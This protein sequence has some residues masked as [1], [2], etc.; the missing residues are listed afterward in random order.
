M[1]VPNIFQFQK[2]NYLFISMLFFC[3]AALIGLFA[4]IKIVHPTFS[5]SIPFIILRPLHTFWVIVALLSGVGGIIYKLTLHTFSKKEHAFYSLN[6]L[7]FIIWSSWVIVTGQ[8]SG[9]EYFSWPL[10][11]S[12][13][14]EMFLIHLLLRLFQSKKE[15]Y[16]QSPEAFWLLALGLLF[17][18]NGLIESQYW[19]LH[20][21][22]KNYVADLSIQWHSID[23]FFAGINT[24][25]YGGAAFLLDTKPKPLRKPVLFGIA[26]FSLLF[27]FGHHHYISPQPTLLKNLALIASLLAVISFWRHVKAYK[28][29][30]PQQF[31]HD[32]TFPL[33]R[34]IEFW[35]L[36]SV[37]SGVLFAIPQFNLWIHSSYLVVI[38]AM[39]SMI[40]VNF[41]IIVLANLAERKIL[42]S[43]NENWLQNPVKWINLSLLGLW[44]TLGLNGFLKGWQRFYISVDYI[45]SFRDNMLLLFPV[46]GFFLLLGIVRL[47]YGLWKLNHMEALSEL[48]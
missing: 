23:T 16:L 36:V 7:C 27:T 13:F 47:S 15:L 22:F 30:N 3:F 10:I 42:T 1:F 20:N 41:M 45:Q 44:I 31:K 35:T 34:A 26:A 28:K 24:A 2:I 9:R 8:A 18:Q 4:A 37:A 40:G 19:H 39:G 25:L 32:L 17:I 11:S 6:F 21:L 5:Q 43:S 29:I 38:H 12:V 46:L 33:W 14:L 48:G